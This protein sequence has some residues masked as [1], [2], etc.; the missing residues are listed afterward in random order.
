MGLTGLAP[1]ALGGV[2]PSECVE[3]RSDDDVVDAIRDANAKRAAV[4][5]W[6]GGTRIDIGDTPHRYDVAVD[7][8]GVR[9]VV[10]HQPGDLTVTVRAGTTI[11]ELQ[12]VLAAHRQWWPVEVAH[13]DRATVGGTIASAAGGPSRYR[14]LHVRDHVV[15]VRAVLGDGTLT[16]AGGRVVKNVTG[17]DLSR[18]YSGTFGTLCAIV[19]ASLKLTPLPERRLTLLAEERDHAAAVR[20]GRQLVASRL[21][22]D[23]LTVAS[24][25]VARALG[26]AS[27]SAILIRVA[28]TTAATRRLEREVAAL[29]PAARE[30]SDTAWQRVADAPADAETSVRV[31]WPAATAIDLDATDALLYPGLETVHLLGPRDAQD[32]TSL[33]AGAEERDGA[34]VL[35]RAP[36]DLRR[37]IGT[38][39]RARVPLAIAERLRAQLDPNGVLAP[40]RVP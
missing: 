27:D 19:E 15:G 2:S 22:L 35:E 1:L 11:A 40:G 3:A 26:A 17:Y 18:L 4:V 38:W 37:A 10:D 36:A 25:S 32:L 5:L 23:A 12:G 21:P 16:R 13:P 33:R 31:S 8:R 29:V 24:G 39:G 20:T 28:G 7:L 34:L 9:G 6:G 14:Y 30:T